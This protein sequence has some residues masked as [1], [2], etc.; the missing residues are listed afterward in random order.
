MVATMTIPMMLDAMKL[1]LGQLENQANVD[2]DQST[3]E[4]IDDF[5]KL[6]WLLEDRSTADSM[7]RRFTGRPLRTRT[8]VNGL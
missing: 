3:E 4:R 5:V 2:V 7:T 8:V 1:T 6:D